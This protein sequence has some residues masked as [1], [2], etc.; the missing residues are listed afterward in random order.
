[1]FINR[2]RFCGVKPLNRD[3]PDGGGSLSGTGSEAVASSGGNGS[4]KQR[5]S[6][7][8]VN[9]WKFWGEWIEIGDRKTPPN[10][11][12]RHFLARADLSAIEL[13]GMLPEK[14][15]VWIGMGESSEWE[16]LKKEYPNHAFAG[17]FR[18]GPGW[19]TELPDLSESTF[20]PPAL[21]HCLVDK[22]N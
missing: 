11:Q 2:L 5:S 7:T 13:G 21:R 6:E 4:G 20:G 10:H 17:L 15:M 8:I 1:M 12:L 16:E 18:K 14:P 19:R 3:I 9:L 22:R